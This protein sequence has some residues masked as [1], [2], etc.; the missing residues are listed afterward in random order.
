MSDDDDDGDYTDTDTGIDDEY[1]EAPGCVWPARAQVAM[2][3]IS[4]GTKEA[5]IKLHKAAC[6]YLERWL[7]EG[8]S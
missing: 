7:G 8:E 1:E 2:R 6:E 3:I 4:M 5:P